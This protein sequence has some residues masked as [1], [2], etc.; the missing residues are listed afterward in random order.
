MLYR[1]FKLI[2]VSKK[3]KVRF[4]TGVS[5]ILN[6]IA[7]ENSAQVR[8]SESFEQ[9]SFRK[10]FILD[11]I[12][13]T[14]V[15]LDLG[16]SEGLTSLFVAEKSKFVFGVDLDSVAIDSATAKA[17]KNTKFLNADGMFF[18]ESGSESIDVVLLS[19]VLEHQEN[20]KGMLE[21]LR[22]RNVKIYIEVPDNDATISQSLRVFLGLEPLRY[23]NDHL[24]EFTRNQ[25]LE[26]FEE[27]GLSVIRKEFKYGVM[28][29]WLNAR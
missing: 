16:C 24:W 29:L 17:R 4:C 5:H 7:Y 25:I 13:V 19:H 23:D 18:L 12:D 27:L 14:D 8:F 1:G 21:L 6:R 28:Y 20:P 15:V 26:L 3:S 22:R 9:W 11:G 10:A 2:P